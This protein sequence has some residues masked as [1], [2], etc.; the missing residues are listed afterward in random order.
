MSAI[1]KIVMLLVALFL[2]LSALFLTT[3][4]AAADCP[5][6]SPTPCRVAS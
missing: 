6:N 3:G 2:G 4:T 1:R 5:W